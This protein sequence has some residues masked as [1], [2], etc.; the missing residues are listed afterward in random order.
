MSDADA[1]YILPLLGVDQET[2][3]EIIEIHISNPE[4]HRIQ[5]YLAKY[6]TSLVHDDE[7]ANQ[8]EAFS[9]IIFARDS[10]TNLNR[11][12]FEQLLDSTRLRKLRRYFFNGTSVS[13]LEF[14]KYVFPEHSNTQLRNMFK[15]GGIR[16]NYKKLT[17]CSELLRLDEL[18]GNILVN[19]GKSSFYIIKLDN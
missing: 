10:S 19:I 12:K 3:N 18:P 11:F 6:I 4:D 16:L 15:S 14:F 13:S 9:K 17:D 2:C 5:K 1:L 8:V 7:L